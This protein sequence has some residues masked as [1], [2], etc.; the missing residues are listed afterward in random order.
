MLEIDRKIYSFKIKEV[1]FSEYP[2]DVRDCDAVIF[3]ECKIMWKWMVLIKK[4]LR[5]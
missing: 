5:R 1:W 4:S 2:F 3:R